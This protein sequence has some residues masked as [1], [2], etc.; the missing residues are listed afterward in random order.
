M[1]LV[2]TR[3]AF[4]LNRGAGSLA[5]VQLKSSLPLPE[6]GAVSV[7]LLV[8]VVQFAATSAFRAAKSSSKSCQA[9]FWDAQ[10]EYAAAFG[11][12][13]GFLELV[14]LWEPLI[15]ET[16]REFQEVFP[17][18]L[19]GLMEIGQRVMGRYLTAFTG[20]STSLLLFFLLWLSFP[21]ILCQTFLWSNLSH[22][23]LQGIGVH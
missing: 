2:A 5:F 17:T 11:R 21:P 7:A 22:W 6:R 10:V 15:S 13:R 3:A 19:P 12:Q 1:P 8:S 4:R 18:A 20:L 23:S 14:L 9:G 16:H